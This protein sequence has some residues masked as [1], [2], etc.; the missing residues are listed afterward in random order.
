MKVAKTK[1]GYR[2]RPLDGPMTL[3]LTHLRGKKSHNTRVCR[4]MWELTD[5]VYRG[6]TPFGHR[7]S[8]LENNSDLLPDVELRQGRDDKVYSS[9][10]EVYDTTL[11]T[12]WEGSGSHFFTAA[13]RG[14][15]DKGRRKFVHGGGNAASCLFNTWRSIIELKMS[16]EGERLQ[17]IIPVPLLYFSKVHSPFEYPDH[18]NKFTKYLEQNC[19]QK[20]YI[21]TVDGE[22]KFQHGEGDRAV[23]LH[24]YKS[25]SAMFA[26][27]FFPE[28]KDQSAFSRVINYFRHI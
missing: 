6:R 15:M 9:T 13:Q 21:V 26:S 17:T 2:I 10:G 7:L 1:L 22:L 8:L 16:Q 12:G 28:L 27:P 11:P 24:W 19:R 14:F 23:E 20:G 18:P 4:R 3:V 5:P 25:L